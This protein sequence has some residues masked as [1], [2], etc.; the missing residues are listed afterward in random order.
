MF[1]NIFQPSVLLHTICKSLSKGGVMG[2]RIDSGLTRRN[3]IAAVGMAWAWMYSG[4][5]LARA[6][7]NEEVSHGAEAIH[8]EVAFS[9]SPK[10]VYDALTETSQFDKVI[11]IGGSK[12]SNSLGTEPTQISTEIGGPF[13]LFGGHIIGRHVELVPGRR[14]VQAWR[15]VDWEQGVYS[16]VRFELKESGTGTRILFDHTGFPAGLGAHLADGWNGHYWDPLRKF[17]A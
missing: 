6:E 1:L 17:L 11:E 2:S 5:N 14:I 13:V 10:R 8:Q 16:I 15:V 9:A 12:K 7:S 4:Q 3:A